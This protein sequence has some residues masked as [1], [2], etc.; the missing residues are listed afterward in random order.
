MPQLNKSSELANSS[1]LCTVNSSI[2]EMVDAFNKNL[3]NILN[4]VAPVKV[5]KRP[6]EKA[7][8][9]INSTICE[10]KRLREK[11]KETGEQPN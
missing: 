5:R 4:K 6:C 11:S 1:D 2:K 9:W 10:L 3:S 8:P 7:R